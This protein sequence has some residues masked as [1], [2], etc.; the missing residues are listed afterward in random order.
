M[1]LK[2]RSD[3]ES[4]S[5]LKFCLNWN[6]N[7]KYISYL[8][9]CITTRNSTWYAHTWQYII[10]TSHKELRQAVQPGILMRFSQG[11]I[12][13][14]LLKPCT[15]YTGVVT[16]N[17]CWSLSCDSFFIKL[18]GID[19]CE[20]HNDILGSTVKDVTT[21]QHKINIFW[22]TKAYYRKVAS[23][24]ASRFVPHLVYNHTQKPDLLIRSSS[25]L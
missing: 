2:N 8:L 11:S 7:W 9:E 6:W 25:R 5:L 13:K 12:L 23:T 20:K 18:S 4:R 22:V 10:T 17:K 19:P 3:I 14:S 21:I 24:N 1:Y 15:F 16:F